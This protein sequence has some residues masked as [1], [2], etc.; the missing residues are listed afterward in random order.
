M[1]HRIVTYYKI[2]SA[3]SKIVCD[4]KLA[5]N[6]SSRRGCR[7]RPGTAQA[8]LFC[9]LRTIHQGM[10]GT[11]LVYKWVKSHQDDQV[12]WQQLSLEAQLNKTC[13]DLA[14]NV[15]TG[16]LANADSTRVKTFL[17]PFEQSAIISNG[18]KITSRVALV[19]WFHL[20]RVEAKKFYKRAIQWVAGSNK[21]GLGW[22]DTKFESVNWKALEHAICNKPEGFQLWLSKQAIG[23]CATQKNTA[24]IQDI[25]DD[26]CPNCRHRREDSTHLN[27]CTDQEDPSYS[28][29]GHGSSIGGCESTTEWISNS[30]F[31]L[32]SISCIVGR[33][34]WPTWE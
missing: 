28:K 19:I 27:K 34:Q 24:R 23:V 25:L 21:G 14:N 15:V 12:P 32:I 13:D 18:V 9:T 2:H 7:I 10:A 11:T 26:R 1:L 5:L 33:N 3:S 29:M 16:A 30:P 22:S 17:L 4:S 6:K 20:G 8:N 31:G